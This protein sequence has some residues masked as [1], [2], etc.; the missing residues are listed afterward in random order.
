MKEFR[1]TLT[2]YAVGVLTIGLLVLIFLN[3]IVIN[4]LDLDT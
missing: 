4:C 1:K 3:N 2:L